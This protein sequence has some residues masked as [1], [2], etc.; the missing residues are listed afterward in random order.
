MKKLLFLMLFLTSC[1]SITMEDYQTDI[2]PFKYQDYEF[3]LN[4]PENIYVITQTNVGERTQ[5]DTRQEYLSNVA[6]DVN[7]EIISKIG[8]DDDTIGSI[9]VSQDV[10]NRKQGALMTFFGSLPSALSLGTLNLIGYPFGTEEYTVKVTANVYDLNGRHLREYSAITKDWKFIACYYGYAPN[11]V[12]AAAYLSAYKEGLAEVLEK[13]KN[14][15]EFHTIQKK[16]EETI[17]KQNKQIA[18]KKKAE[19]AK[20]KALQREA[21]RK[22]EAEKQEH[23]QSVLDELKGI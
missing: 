13:I 19:E 22:Q 7:K 17:K 1:R 12:Q 23:L 2:A 21:K 18:L 11:Q 9:V 15:D 16:E 4:V 8:N 20:R 5:I 6:Y 14:D 10:F 3:T